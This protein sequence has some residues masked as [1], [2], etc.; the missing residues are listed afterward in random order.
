M[1]KIPSRHR[2]CAACR[3]WT[4]CRHVFRQTATRARGGGR[5]NSASSLGPRLLIPSPW[6]RARAHP[7]GRRG[8][9]RGDTLDPDFGGVG[10]DAVVIFLACA[11]PRHQHRRTTRNLCPATGVQHRPFVANARCC[12][13]ITSTCS[14]RCRTSR[15]NFRRV[16]PTHQ[17]H[18]ASRTEHLALHVN[19][20]HYTRDF[21][22]QHTV[23][24]RRTRSLRAPQACRWPHFR[25]AS[26]DVHHRR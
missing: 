7:L 17:Q 16:V 22:S 5:R 2:T 12:K 10:V 18:T 25:P 6:E 8:L 13:Y 23:G 15:S 14:S 20:H 3:L 11:G 24:H 9:G 19:M 1:L 4:A 21:L 26:G